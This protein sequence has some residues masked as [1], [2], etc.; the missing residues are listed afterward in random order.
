MATATNTPMVDSQLL[1]AL[2]QQRLRARV[3][4]APGGIAA[5]AHEIRAQLAE[6]D[7]RDMSSNAAGSGTRV[8]DRAFY[9]AQLEY[10]DALARAANAPKPAE[11]PGLLARLR[12]AFGRRQPAK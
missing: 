8:T 5:V 6:L 12:S 2:A 1:S 3:A 9:V 7:A 4:D 11:R 10:L